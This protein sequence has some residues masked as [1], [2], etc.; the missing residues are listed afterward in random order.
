MSCKLQTLISWAGIVGSVGEA[1][2]ISFEAAGVGH[3]PEA[4]DQ[5]SV[6]RRL[7]IEQDLQS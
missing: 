6:Q 7:C 5:T 1:G 3:E 2:Q 4:N